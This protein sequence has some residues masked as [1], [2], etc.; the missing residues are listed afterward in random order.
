ML[1]KC[2]QQR[3]SWIFWKGQVIGAQDWPSNTQQAITL[4]NNYLRLLNMPEIAHA[5]THPKHNTTQPTD[6][7]KGLLQTNF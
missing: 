7:L 2:G 5:R 4:T 3:Q 1:G 6:I